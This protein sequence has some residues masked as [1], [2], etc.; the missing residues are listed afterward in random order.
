ML[1]QM[2]YLQYYLKDPI[3]WEV[4]QTGKQRLDLVIPVGSQVSEYLP[5]KIARVRDRVSQHFL[6]SVHKK[7]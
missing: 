2:E 4:P 7:D 3:D 5:P 1:Y 6:M